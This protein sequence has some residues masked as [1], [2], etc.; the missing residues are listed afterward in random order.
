MQGKRR[1]KGK[2]AEMAKQEPKENLPAENWEAKKRNPS[3]DE[4][5]E[6]QAKSH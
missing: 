4:V 1:E 2:Q 5:E 3:S 6:K